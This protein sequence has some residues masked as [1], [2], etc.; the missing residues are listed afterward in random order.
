MLQLQPLPLGPLRL[1][2]SAPRHRSVVLDVDIT[3]SATARRIE[4]P[5]R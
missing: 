1:Y 2:V 3:H 5:A 4:L